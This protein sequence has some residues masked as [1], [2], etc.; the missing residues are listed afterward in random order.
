MGFD[1]LLRWRGEAVSGI[2]NG[3]D[4]EIWNPATDMLIP[5]R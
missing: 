4:T 2:L 3:I 5:A 1:G